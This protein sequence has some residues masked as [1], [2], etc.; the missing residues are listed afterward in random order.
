MDDS[1]AAS[2]RFGPLLAMVVG[3]CI[4]GCGSGAG[5]L[6]RDVWGRH[7]DAPAGVQRYLTGAGGCAAGRPDCAWSLIYDDSDVVGPAAAVNGKGCS[8]T[9]PMRTPTIGV[10]R[11]PTYR[12]QRVAGADEPELGETLEVCPLG[13]NLAT[14]PVTL[15]LRRSDGSRISRRVAPNTEA[16]ASDRVGSV[17][18][19]LDATWPLGRVVVTA[20]QGSKRVQRT[21]RLVA[22]RHRGVRVQRWLGRPRLPNPMTI[23]VVGQ[24]PRSSVLVDLYRT[25]RNRYVYATSF[26][27]LTDGRGIGQ[28]RAPYRR[29]D[30]GAYRLRPRAG[31]SGDRD[32]EAYVPICIGCCSSFPHQNAYC[33]N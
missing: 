19:F 14:R 12:F 7:D 1:S 30:N 13:F 8:N 11:R 32:L 21:F 27:I 22:P 4:A 31:A 23:L 17:A 26:R 3:A 20:R 10:D 5:A 6:P 33:L 18:F 25:D 2:S 24:R 15:T 16:L 28:V 29:A 9:P